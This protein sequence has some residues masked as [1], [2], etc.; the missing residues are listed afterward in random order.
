M[1]TFD[2][3]FG[4]SIELLVGNWF[5]EQCHNASLRWFLSYRPSEGG[6][7]GVLAI[8]PEVPVNYTNVLHLSPSWTLARALLRVREIAAT[9]PIL[10]TVSR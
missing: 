1:P 9:L 5:R 10:P 4:K 8:T 2:D 7:A 3:H 6:A